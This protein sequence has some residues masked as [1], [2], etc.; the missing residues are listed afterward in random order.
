M[1]TPSTITLLQQSGLVILVSACVGAL[2]ACA[3]GTGNSSGYS[4]YSG[5]AGVSSQNVQT[6]SP[7]PGP[8]YYQSSQDPYHQN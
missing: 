5:G 1:K 4:G 2:A 8:R 6:N 7:L 3:N